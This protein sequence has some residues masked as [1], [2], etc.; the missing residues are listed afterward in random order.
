MGD[1]QTM[2]RMIRAVSILAAT[3]AIGT[4]TLTT[5]LTPDA[6]AA[7]SDPGLEQPAIATPAAIG[8]DWEGS[9]TCVQ[10]LTG[11]DLKI[12]R[13]GHSNSLQATF[14]FYPLASNPA[15]PVG[16]YTMRGTY[17]SA[18]KIVFHG[19]RWILRPAGYVMVGLSGR[20]SGGRFHGAVHGPSCTTFSLRKPKGHPSRANLVAIWKGSYLGCGQGPTGLRLT[21]KRMG[22]SGS[23]L[24]ATFSFHAL[25][26]NPTVPSGS[27][28]MT[29]YYFPGGVAL[30]GT[31]WIRQPPGYSMVNLVGAPPPPGGKKFRGA[32]VGC[33]KFALERP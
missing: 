30:Y 26:S 15:V 20:L 27:Y 7:Q 6:L 24:R 33:A 10:G 31:H 29:G 12:S 4:G 22:R 8:E 17:R 28:A 13:S 1:L 25:P 5:A 21:V 11:L 23:K 3:I 32:I 18:S 2:K 9:Y 14:S 16:I 19:R